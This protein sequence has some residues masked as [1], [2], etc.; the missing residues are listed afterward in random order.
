MGEAGFFGIKTPKE[1]GGAGGDHVSYVIV[2]EEIAKRSAVASVFVS[3]PNSPLRCTDSIKRYS[4][5]K[6]K[7]LK[8]DRYRRTYLL[9]WLNRTGCRFRRRRHQDHGCF[10]DGDNG[11]LTDVKPLSPVHP[12]QTTA[13]ST[14][15]TRR[16]KVAQASPPLSST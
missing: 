10:R 7:V 16:Q 3:S 11:F 12:L 6:R 13:L 2:M 14:P 5:T 15:R 9:L 1:Y 8:Q 4:R